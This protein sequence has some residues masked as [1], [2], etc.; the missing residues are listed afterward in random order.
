M[1]NNNY[2]CMFVIKCTTKTN[3]ILFMVSFFVSLS[4]VVG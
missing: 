4:S 2:Y 3:Y 1:A